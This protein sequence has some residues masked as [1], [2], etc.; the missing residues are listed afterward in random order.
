[1]KNFA[2]RWFSF[3]L[4]L[5]IAVCVNAQTQRPSI[6]LIHADDLGYGDVS[7]YGATTIKTP[8]MDRLAREGLRFTDAHAS[9]ATCT[10]SRYAMLTGEYAWRKKGTG[11]LPGDAAMVIDTRQTTLAGLLQKA[12]YTT[13]VVGKWHNVAAHHPEKVQEMSARLQKIRQDGRSR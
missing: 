7:S 13:G 10:P 4:V 12:E 3:S 9:A 11:V 5:L 2:I 8:N 1:M 6:V